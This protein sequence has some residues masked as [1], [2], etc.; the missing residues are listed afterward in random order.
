MRKPPRWMRVAGQIL[1]AAI[2]AFALHAM[3]VSWMIVV[4]LAGLAAAVSIAVVRRP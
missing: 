2:G 3:G 4:L 1:F